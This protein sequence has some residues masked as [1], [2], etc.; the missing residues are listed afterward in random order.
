LSAAARV[1]WREAADHFPTISDAVASRR[2]DL[3]PHV[4]GKIREYLSV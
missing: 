3:R 2:G 4:K 1:F